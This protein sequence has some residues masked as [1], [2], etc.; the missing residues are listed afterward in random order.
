MDRCEGYLYIWNV[1]LSS[2]LAL[3]D[4]TQLS[5]EQRWA[6]LSDS[7]FTRFG[8]RNVFNQFIAAS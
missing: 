2:V 5:S 4:S 8:R 1:A 7:S 3:F 6:R